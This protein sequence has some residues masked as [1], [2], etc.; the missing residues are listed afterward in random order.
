MPTNGNNRPQE[1]NSKNPQ[2]HSLNIPD[3]P[4]YYI[5]H[6]R[7]PW[8][9]NWKQFI[10]CSHGRIVTATDKP[11]DY[12]LSIPFWGRTYIPPWDTKIPFK[13]ATLSSPYTHLQD[14]SIMVLTGICSPPF[15]ISRLGSR[16]ERKWI[17]HDYT[18]VD[19]YDPNKQ[20]TKFTN[21]IGS[22]GKFYAISLH[23]TL[24]LIEEVGSEF[25]I[26]GIGK[27]KA[28]PSVPSKHF[29]EYLTVRWGDFVDFPHLKKINPQR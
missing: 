13:F 17:E 16:Q 11:P 4:G 8:R 28:V 1:Y 15:L 23:G 9:E 2:P 10:G 18:L 19:H 26:T 5:W 27:N 22:M 12:Y 14:S 21:A 24:A 29:K 20:L 7:R 3:H 25:R 6:G